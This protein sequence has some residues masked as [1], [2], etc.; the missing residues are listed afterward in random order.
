MFLTRRVIVHF[1][2]VLTVQ[3][4]DLLVELELGLKIFDCLQFM[5]L[6]DDLFQYYLRLGLRLLFQQPLCVL[7]VFVLNMLVIQQVVVLP[8]PVIE[9]SNRIEFFVASM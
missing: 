5:V 2:F 3:L 1:L 6:T 7:A 4:C 9:Q 8:D